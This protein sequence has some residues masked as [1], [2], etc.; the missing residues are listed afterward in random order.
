MKKIRSLLSTFMLQLDR[1]DSQLANAAVKGQ[2]KYEPTAT[3]A[4]VQ[5]NS[6]TSLFMCEDRFRPKSLPPFLIMFGSLV[7]LSYSLFVVTLFLNFSKLVTKI[8][9]SVNAPHTDHM[10]AVMDLNVVC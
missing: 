9:H 4:V 6:S 1:I 7:L 10:V 2:F 3:S 5:W 8:C